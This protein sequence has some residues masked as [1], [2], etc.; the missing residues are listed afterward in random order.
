MELSLIWPPCA[1]PDPHSNLSLGNWLEGC[2]S[3]FCF[4]SRALYMLLAWHR[5]VL[6]SPRSE[7]FLLIHDLSG[8]SSPLWKTFLIPV[9][10]IYNPNLSDLQV[11]KWPSR[12]FPYFSSLPPDYYLYGEWILCMLWLYSHHPATNR[13]LGTSQL[14]DMIMLIDSPFLPVQLLSWAAHFYLLSLDSF[15]LLQGCSGILFFCVCTDMRLRFGNS[16]VKL[17]P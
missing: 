11:W 16:F 6:H 9:N 8:W 13:N 1:S 4:S 12:L 15:Q 10:W 5:P 17:I 2:Q 7:Y 14:Y 3:P